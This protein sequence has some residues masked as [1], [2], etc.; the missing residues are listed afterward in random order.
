MNK[1]VF[2]IACSLMGLIM[3]AQYTQIPD[4]QFENSLTSY[5][6]VP[7]DGQV[8]TANIQT[9]T[10]LDVADEGINDLTG[11]EDFTGLVELY[12]YENL[13]STIDL[14]NNTALEILDLSNLPLAELDLSSLTA[15]RELNLVNNN[16]TSLNLSSNINL[17]SLISTGNSIERYDL[18][19]NSS[20]STLV[21]V[22][23]A[24]KY[25]NLKNGNNSNI[26]NHSIYGDTSLCVSVDDLTYA[27]NNLTN[28]Q[29]TSIYTDSYCRYTSIPDS[30]FESALEGLGYDDVSGD[31]QI[32]TILV[33]NVT[34]LQINFHSIE[35]LAGIE[36]FT[37][38]QELDVLYGTLNSVDVSQNLQLTKL[39]CGYNS[40][41]TT[42]DV[43]N[44]SLLENIFVNDTSIEVLDFSNNPNLSNIVASSN[45]SLVQLNL[46]NGNNTAITN[47]LLTGTTNL[48]CIQ[49]DDADYA[50][51]NF[52]NIDSANS[53]S[54]D[55]ES[56]IMT[57]RVFLEGPF[58]SSEFLM[59]DDL[60]SNSLLPTTSPYADAATCDSSVFDITNSSAIV[61]WVEIQLRNANDI[62]EIVVRKSVLLQKNS[63]VRDVTGSASDFTV[64]AWQGNYYV[65]IAHRNHLTV[66]TNTPI[67]FDGDVKNID[68]TSDGSVLNGANAMVEVVNSIFA[69]PAGNVEGSGQIQN[70][71]ISNT[72]QQ[73]GISGYSIF[74][75]DMNGQVQNTD[76]NLIQQNIGKGEQF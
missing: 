40:G 48:T 32:P 39:W 76:I 49:V 12:A 26:V 23:S 20:L 72:I 1:Y 6:D 68:F 11:I 66:V 19:N 31:G 57:T 22:S 10:R 58:N 15:L 70:S 52:T 45:T 36:D 53:F 33:E 27:Q 3:N 14:S 13:F 60:R 75:V 71:G 67:T 5:D 9:V 62:N 28:A 54:T 59:N 56:C 24:T 34:S 44:N 30:N 51:S 50:N 25:I 69:L 18:R 29:S 73:L 16:L 74:D 47:L 55:C 4:S 65:A 64:S 21:I 61:D 37:A 38:L 17:T 7:G 2:F 41:I 43:S 46:R 35:N 63:A 42:L 8:P